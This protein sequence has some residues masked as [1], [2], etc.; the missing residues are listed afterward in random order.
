MTLDEEL[1]RIFADERLAVTTTG[2]ASKRIV[3]GAR[4]IRTR[5]RNMAIG[6]SGL[7]VA[8]VFSAGFCLLPPT[9]PNPGMLPQALTDVSSTAAQAGAPRM[10]VIR[11]DGAEPIRW[12]MSAS[13]VLGTGAV[14]PVPENTGP[15]YVPGQLTTWFHGDSGTLVGVNSKD[16]VSYIRATDQIRTEQGVAP[17]ATAA[18]L[19][20]AYPGLSDQDPSVALTPDRRLHFEVR[21]G[22]VS[23]VALIATSL[24][25]AGAGKAN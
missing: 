22:T 24:R 14:K 3:A 11:A 8:G 20:T 13:E 18:E 4:R 9:A 10:R 12:G 15:C 25:C 6:A 21:D 17:G 7:A 1:H 16:G 23:S 5:R 2:E 19:H